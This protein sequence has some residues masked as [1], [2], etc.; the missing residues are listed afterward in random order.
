MFI[1]LQDSQLGHNHPLQFSRTGP[2]QLCSEA[3]TLPKASRKQGE[4][5]N[6]RFSEMFWSL[7]VLEEDE[8]RS[9]THSSSSCD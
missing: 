9:A 5:G 3:Q 4:W 7:E 1:R 6:Y 2:A 8:D